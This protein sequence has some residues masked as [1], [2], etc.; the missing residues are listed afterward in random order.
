[1]TSV[2]PLTNTNI[3]RLNPGPSSS[4]AAALAEQSAKKRIDS[5]QSM[6]LVASLSVFQYHLWTNY[7]GQRFL[8]PGTDFFLVLVGM[9]AAMSEAGKI[10]RGEWKNYILGRYLR[11]YVT[12]IPVFLLYVLGGAG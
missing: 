4:S 5:L 6:R 3:Q 8:Y 11:L 1:M 10:A 12:F 7:L 9:V 2:Q